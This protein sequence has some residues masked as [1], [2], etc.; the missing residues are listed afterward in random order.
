[1]TDKQRAP[2]ED[3]GR[4]GPVFTADQAGVFDIR[5]GK[6]ES[7]FGPVNCEH[8][9]QHMLTATTSA[10]NRSWILRCAQG[11]EKREVAFVCM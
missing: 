1:M 9:N 6:R 2:V 11:H 5:Y 7:I 3:D 10:D 8:C 4:D